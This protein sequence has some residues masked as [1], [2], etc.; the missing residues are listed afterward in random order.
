MIYDGLILLILVLATWRGASRGLAWQV[1]WIGAI[2]L[3]FLFATPLSLYVTPLIKLDPP[4]NR[5]VG[6]LVIYMGFS[7]VS[8]AIARTLRGWLEETKFQE[9]DSHLGAILGLAKGTLIALVLTFFL[10]GLSTSARDYILKTN[11]GYAAEAIFRKLHPIMPREIE[12]VLEKYDHF[13]IP[14]THEHLREADRESPVDFQPHR[15]RSGYRPVDEAADGRADEPS[16]KVVDERASTGEESDGPPL[17]DLLK[18][19]PDLFGGSSSEQSSES[20]SKSSSGGSTGLWDS[21]KSKLPNWPPSPAS[22][23]PGAG[24]A[25]TRDA[26]RPSGGRDELIAG[27]VRVMS[28]DARERSALAGEVRAGLSGVPDQ[29]A[30]AALHDWLIDLTGG[31]SDPDPDT[32]VTSPLDRR[33]VRQLERLGVPE[34]RLNQALRERLRRIEK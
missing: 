8:F 14:V 24:S 30:T 17:A 20:T 22:D 10:V 16:D 12:H 2:V 6:M 4:L 28:A 7:F 32:D 15:G 33:I 23:Q 29:V 21:I 3:C 11:S 25:T 31:G 26:D 5:W 18:H 9:F 19:L 27:V 34:S 13:G 1:A